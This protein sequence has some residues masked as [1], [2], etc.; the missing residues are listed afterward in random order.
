MKKTRQRLLASLLTGAMLLSMCSGALAAEPETKEEKAV[1]SVQTLKQNEGYVDRADA[2]EKIYEYFNW[3]HRDEYN[4]IWAPDM[5]HFDDVAEGSDG[6]MAIECLLQQSVVD[7]AETFRP[8]DALT[9]GEAIDML[10]RAFGVD[11]DEVAAL[12]TEGYD[13][14]AAIPTA[15]WNAAFEAMTEDYVSP[16]Q[17]LPIANSEAIAPRRY[18]KLWTPTEGATIYVSKSVSLDGYYED[19]EVDVENAVEN[20]SGWSSV[21][22]NEGETAVTK[23]TQIYTVDEDGYIKEDY[24]S[25]ADTYVT[26]KVVAVKDGVKSAERTYRWHL[27]RPIDA[28]KF[29]ETEMDYQHTLIREGD[30][31]SP[32]VYQIC[33]DAETLRPMA[34]YVE[35]SESGI[36]ID[37]LFTQAS[38]EWNLKEY[39]DSTLR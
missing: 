25:Y 35:G 11:G 39:V 24:G 29:S 22:F 4:D 7:E 34:W 1:S 6:W 33:R 9:Y 27:Q 14:K 23:P 8:Q 26:Y 2:A 12:M 19:F 30:E 16:V 17:A 3:S 5:V 36:V 28:E 37:A 18:I 15:E 38:S 13:E 10:S 32:T 31:N 20:V 21:K